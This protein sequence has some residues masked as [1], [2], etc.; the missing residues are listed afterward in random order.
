MPISRFP[1]TLS[2]WAAGL[3]VVAG[4][5]PQV[6]A[7]PVEM[8]P[9]RWTGW[10]RMILDGGNTERVKCVATY[11]SEKGGSEL[12]HNLRCASTNYRIDAVAQ[13]KVSG[14]RVSGEWQERTY[15]TGGGVSGRVNGDGI[16]VRIV[17]DQ[18]T[19]SMTVDTGRCAQSMNIAPTGMGVQ[20]IAVELKKC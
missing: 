12:R 4:F 2:S 11:F 15:V 8:L 18:F 13:L 9:G 16:A 14:T 19:A 1:K 3:V 10:G 7:G 5:A 20:R 6:L 17:G